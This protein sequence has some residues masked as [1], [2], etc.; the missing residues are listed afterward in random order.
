[1]GA[2]PPRTRADPFV[3]MLRGEIRKATPGGQMHDHPWWETI[4]AAV[5]VTDA[6]GIIVAMNDASKTTFAA[7]GGGDLIGRSVFDCHP[8]PALTRTRDL[9]RDRVPNHYTIE[10]DGRRRSSTRS[11]YSGRGSSVD[12][13]RSRFRFRNRCPISSGTK[14]SETEGAT[15]SSPDSPSAAWRP[16]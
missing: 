4:P 11:P 5:T 13:S 7:D 3:G 10:K 15:R 12:S 14:W 8:E 16:S 2:A 9:Y 1:M 6:E